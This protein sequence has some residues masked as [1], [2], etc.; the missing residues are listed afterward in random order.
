MLLERSTD[1]SALPPGDRIRFH[2]KLRC[3]MVVF[4]SSIL[5]TA[6]A[7]S[8]LKLLSDKLSERRRHVSPACVN[9]T[10]NNVAPSAPMPLSCKSSIERAQKE[11]WCRSGELKCRDAAPRAGRV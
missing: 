10:L 11:R 7:P 3:V 9:D 2:D 4:D 6:A 5:D 8:D 1:A